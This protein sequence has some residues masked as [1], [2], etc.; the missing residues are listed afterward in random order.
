MKRI[1][2]VAMTLSLTA[3]VRPGDHPLN[4]TC[5]WIEADSRSLNLENAAD[6]R[7]LRFD[8]ITAEDVA[9][10]WADQQAG[11]LPE[12][13]RRRDECMDALFSGVAR[14]HGVD[15]ATVRQFRGERDTLGDASVILSFGVLYAVVAIYLVGRIRRRFPA[16]EP[17]FW[18][19]TITMSV[20]VA[21][22]G[23]LVGYLWS[24]TLEIFRLND[25]HLSY[26]AAQ[27]PW[28]QYWPVMYFAC[29]V[30]FW[31][32]AVIRSGH[33]VTQSENHYFTDA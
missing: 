14:Q 11:H 8:A 30:I 27:I 7:H 28:R 21:A 25:G 1:V 26:R 13:E 3:C 33:R 17:G 19:M 18:I 16:G 23:A 22:V 15:V 24:F 5:A 10:R 9:I 31:L 20:C 2:L 4:S 29:L 12:Y 32:V 6:R